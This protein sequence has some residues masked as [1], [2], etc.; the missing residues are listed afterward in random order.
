MQSEEAK[1]LFANLKFVPQVSLLIMPKS[2][3]K[4]ATE[5]LIKRIICQKQFCSETSLCHNCQKLQNDSYFDLQCYQFNATNL[6]KKQDV[7][8]IMAILSQQSIEQSNPKICLLEGIEYSSLEAVNSFLKFLENLPSNTYVIFVSGN[9]GKVLPTIKS[10]SQIFTLTNE[11]KNDEKNQNFSTT[12]FLLVKDV[13]GKFIHYDNTQKFSKNFFLIKEITETK[14]KIY[15]FLQFLLLLAE[16]KLIGFSDNKLDKEIT[17]TLNIWKN[18]HQKFLI[19]MIECLTELIN[20]FSNTK[21]LNL[22][23]MLNYF[24][25][26]LYQGQENGW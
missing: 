22:N 11:Q 3:F 21:N 13:V 18:K 19:N 26:R 10:R 17:A 7:S 9:V 2:F 20:K 6:M 5:Q 24:F 14:E 4:L 25:I 15:L 12:N 16:Q 8:S 23:L 1:L